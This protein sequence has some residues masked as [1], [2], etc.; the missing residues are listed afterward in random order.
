MTTGQGVAVYD[1]WSGSGC[2]WPLVREWLSITTGQG[3]AVYD[4]WSGSGCL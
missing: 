3:V 4:H 2:L 1:H